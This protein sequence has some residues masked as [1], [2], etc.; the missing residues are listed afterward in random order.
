[1]T[2]PNL[3]ITGQCIGCLPSSIPID[4]QFGTS[5]TIPSS[6][7]GKLVASVNTGSVAWTGPALA[8]NISFTMHN[9]DTGTV[10]YTPASGTV[11]GT[12]KQIIP[13]NWFGTEYTD[14]SN[15][16]LLLA[17][18]IFAFPSCSATG[19]FLNFTTATGV[20]G[21]ASTRAVG[22]VTHTAGT[23]TAGQI[24]LG[25][26]GADSTVDPDAS[27]DGAGNFSL[28]SVKITGGGAFATLP[29][30]T[31]GIEGTLSHV[32]D[33]TTNTWGA[34]ITG[35]STNHVLAYCDG[36]AWTVAAK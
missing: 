29:T 33:S 3:T 15:T 22:T 10:T 2:V 21:C 27:S 25:N 34:T 5:Y 19:S 7:A 11:N 16:Y 6:D 24:M 26:S 14:N 30:C 28:T 23:L 13:P 35:G 20:I 31:S 4:N 32:T 17:P 1:V 9:H 36:S 18:S 12:A 8:N